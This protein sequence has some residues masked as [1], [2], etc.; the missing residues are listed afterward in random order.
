MR[1]HL[2]SS[3]LLLSLAALVGT[4]PQDQGEAVENE[5]RAPNYADCREGLPVATALRLRR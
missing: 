2:L 5:Q 1:T 3:L 4:V